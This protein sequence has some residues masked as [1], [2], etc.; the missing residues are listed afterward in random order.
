M[1]ILA[2]RTEMNDVAYHPLQPTQFAT[3]D[4]DGRLLLHDARMA[5][6]DDAM[7]GQL[8]SEV[9]VLHYCT[10]LLK[11]LK[12]A[13]PNPILPTTEIT[14]FLPATPS[15]SS[16]TFSPDGNLLC[17]TV[18]QYL[19]TLFELSSPEPLATFSSTRKDG[20]GYR[21]TTTTKHGSFGS[22]GDK[23]WYS[24]GSDDFNAYIWEVPSVAA[25]K[26]A[27]R[28]PGPNAEE[29]FIGDTPNI[30]EFMPLAY[31]S[32]IADSAPLSAV[33]FDTRTH[34]NPGFTLPASLST[35]SSILSAH[36]SIV[37]TTLF[38]PTLPLLFTSGIEKMVQVHSPT[39][40]PGHSTPFVPR[41]PRP[42]KGG[43]DTRDEDEEEAQG[44]GEDREALEYFDA[45]LQDHDSNEEAL[46]RDGHGRGCLGEEE[47][48]SE[49]DEETRRAWVEAFGDEVDESEEEGEGE[50][51]SGEEGWGTEQDSDSGVDD[52]E[53]E[54]LLRQATRRDR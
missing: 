44:L 25:L 14:T 41:L 27:R 11:P 32:A 40:F 18:S 54:L 51:G 46:W 42:N 24:A 30:G 8:A 34:T 7:Q 45:L 38:H 10:D 22:S 43:L 12:P 35:P 50:G 17:A 49:V 6:S 20:K 29:W 39:P 16:L 48:D 4:G 52:E 37:N 1:G 23:L 33:V 2:E 3:A 47:D 26:E 21:N 28:A 19:P 31:A 5:F 36:R 13:E 9:A 15:A 53:L